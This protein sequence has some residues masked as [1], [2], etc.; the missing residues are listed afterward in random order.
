MSI[1]TLGPGTTMPRMTVISRTTFELQP[2]DRASPPHTP[3][4]QR[5]LFALWKRKIVPPPAP[6]GRRS[7]AWIL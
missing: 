7:S 3:S 6:K 1:T 4:N 5:S 2:W